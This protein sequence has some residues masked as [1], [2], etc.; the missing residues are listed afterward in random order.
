LTDVVSSLSDNDS[1]GEREWLSMSVIESKRGNNPFRAGINLIVVIV[2]YFIQSNSAKPS[3]VARFVLKV[4]VTFPACHNRFFQK[5]L[6]LFPH[7]PKMFGNEL[8]KSENIFV[9]RFEPA[10]FALSYGGPMWV[11]IWWVTNII[12]YDSGSVFVTAIPA[13]RSDQR[14]ASSRCDYRKTQTIS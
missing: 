11:F 2:C 6:P 3:K 1:M 9:G 8:N 5:F 13:S 12:H 4:F 14:E 7:L 10:S